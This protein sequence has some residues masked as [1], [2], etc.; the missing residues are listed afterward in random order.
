[1][2]EPYAE[3]SCNP[4]DTPFYQFILNVKTRLA[5]FGCSVRRHLGEVSYAGR[6][7]H[8]QLVYLDPASPP[9]TLP[10]SARAVV[11]QQVGIEPSTSRCCKSLQSCRF[12]APQ[13]ALAAMI[14]VGLD[15]PSRCPAS[16]GVPVNCCD[17]YYWFWYILAPSPPCLK[18]CRPLSRCSSVPVL[19]ASTYN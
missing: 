1:M 16:S 3:Q 13:Y 14:G 18:L 6:G 17:Y 9:C 8:H 7:V 4:H 11:Q 10:T 19:A 5:T 12:L 2:C 15:T